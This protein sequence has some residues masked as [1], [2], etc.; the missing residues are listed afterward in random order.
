MQPATWS[1]DAV[2]KLMPARFRARVRKIHDMNVASVPRVPTRIVGLV[3][4]AMFAGV[5]AT[6]AAAQPVGDQEAGQAAFE[7]CRACHALSPSQNGRGPTL[8]RLFGRRAGTQLGYAYS[9]AMRNSVIVWTDATLE[10][11]L[12]SPHEM[13]PGTKMEFAG[14]KDRQQMQ[15]L[16]VYLRKA[17][18]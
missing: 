17:T 13:I 11:Y 9:T 1:D 6:M 3:V 7:Q 14:I 2:T 10:R 16:L 18:K 8:Y 5:F 4:T 12:T 15:N